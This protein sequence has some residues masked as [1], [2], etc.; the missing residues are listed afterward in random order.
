LKVIGLSNFLDGSILT[1]DVTNIII[2]KLYN[3]YNY[4]IIVII[5]ATW[6]FKYQLGLTFILPEV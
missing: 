5:N 4:I 1:E 2:Y 6:N 3:I